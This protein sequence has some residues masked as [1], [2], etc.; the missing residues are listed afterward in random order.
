MHIQMWRYTLM[1]NIEVGSVVTYRLLPK[2]R[3]KNPQ[4]LWSGKV[5][6]VVMELGV[7]WVLSVFNTMGGTHLIL[8]MGPAFRFS[9]NQ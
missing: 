6:R 4:R 2:D 1:G 7:V 8:K 5:T 3:P 9:M